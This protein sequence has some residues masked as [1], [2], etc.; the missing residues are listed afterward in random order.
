MGEILCWGKGVGVISMQAGRWSSGQEGHPEDSAEREVKGPRT[1]SG[2]A[3]IS[4][5]RQSKDTE[6]DWEEVA[7]MPGAGCQER[8]GIVGAKENDN[9]TTELP[10]NVTLLPRAWANKPLGRG[11]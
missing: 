11:Q 1:Q 7:R 4:G 6:G 3:P 10:S 5:G 9:F 2:I 8:V